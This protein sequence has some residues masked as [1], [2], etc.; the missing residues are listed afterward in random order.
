MIRRR[1]MITALV[2][3][4]CPSWTHPVAL[5]IFMERRERWRDGLVFKGQR[6]MAGEQDSSAKF[7]RFAGLINNSGFSRLPTE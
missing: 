6:G 4:R 3:E 1:R 2:I 5:F 7:V